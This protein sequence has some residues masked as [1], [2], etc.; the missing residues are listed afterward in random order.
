MHGIKGKPAEDAGRSLWRSAGYARRAQIGSEMA[1]GGE[2]ESNVLRR[3]RCIPAIMRVTNKGECKLDRLSS[4]EAKKRHGQT[5]ALMA[6][7]PAADKR[8]RFVPTVDKLCA[9]PE[10]VT[11][12]GKQFIY[13]DA[14]HLRRNIGQNVRE[15]I[16]EQKIG[17][18]TAIQ[19]S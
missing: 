18:S 12:V 11:Y 2:L 10:C 8:V 14:H 7:L 16:E 15:T 17:L 1:E 3:H 13:R 19:G 4:S 6:R 9:G 5:D